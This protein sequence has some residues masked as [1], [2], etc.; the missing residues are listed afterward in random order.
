MTIFRFNIEN[1]VFRL[2]LALVAAHGV[3]DFDSVWWVVI[4]PLFWAIPDKLTT[5]TFFTLSLVHFAEDLGFI[6]STVLHSLILFSIAFECQQLAFNVVVCFIGCIH[7]PLHYSMC[8][9]NRRYIALSIAALSTCVSVVFSQTRKFETFVFNGLM[10]RVVSA[11]VVVE[12]L[13]K[14]R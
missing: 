8:F 3:T 13:L 1:D 12:S 6:A 4:Y 10:Q 14:H 9:H 2:I 5:P 11:H 7:V